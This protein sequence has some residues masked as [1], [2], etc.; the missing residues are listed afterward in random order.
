[1]AS[2]PP[3]SISRPAVAAISGAWARYS[4]TASTPIGWVR[5]SSHAG[6]RI[7]GSRSTIERSRSY[8]PLPAPT[9]IAA[10]K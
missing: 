3:I 8:E 7:A 6:V 10:R 2:G 5:L 4:T 9:T 1:M